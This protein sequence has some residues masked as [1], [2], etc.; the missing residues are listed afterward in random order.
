[1]GLPEA[2]QHSFVQIVRVIHVRHIVRNATTLLTVKNT[3]YRQVNVL[4]VKMVGLWDTVT[5]GAT[6]MPGVML[7]IP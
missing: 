5:A 7:I 6:M 1:M 2:F 3:T 4:N